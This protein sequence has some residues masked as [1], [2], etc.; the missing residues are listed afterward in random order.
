MP[1]R[2]PAFS[3]DPTSRRRHP[4]GRTPAELFGNAPHKV[5]PA[6]LDLHG[7]TI[8]IVEDHEDSREMLR[9]IVE[10]FGA[11]AAVAADGREALATAAWLRPELVFCDLRMPVLDGYAFIERLRHDPALSRTAVLAVTALGT[12]ADLRKTWAAGFDGHLVKPV[13]YDVI[14]QQ[15]ERVFWAHRRKP[16]R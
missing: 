14:A 11:K 15:L 16:K 12:D 5:T 13:D 4:H 10:S 6:D 2:L 8:L 7:V 3:A 1:A 9:Q